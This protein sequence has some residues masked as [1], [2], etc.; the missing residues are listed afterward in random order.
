MVTKATVLLE[1]DVNT[2]EH[3]HFLIKPTAGVTTGVKAKKRYTSD[4]G[5]GS[6]VPPIFTTGVKA[7]KGYTSD[8]VYG[9]GGYL[10]FSLPGSKPKKGTPLIKA[11]VGE[12]TPIF[13]TGVKAKKRY[14][15]DQGYGRGRYL[16]FSLPGSKPKKG[17]PLIKATVGEDTSNFH[18]RGQSPKRVYP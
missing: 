1:G 12:D 4:Q 9:R 16:Q 6:G 8:Q 15:S 3:L 10:Q 7:K 5:Y 14:A 2:R 17:I 18:Y 13:T 11:T